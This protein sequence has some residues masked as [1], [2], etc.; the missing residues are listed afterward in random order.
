MFFGLFV[1]RFPDL[2]VLLHKDS[3]LPFWPSIEIKKWNR[4]HMSLL[5]FLKDIMMMILKHFLAF[6]GSSL[7]LMN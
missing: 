5:G 4:I 2:I 1:L 7:A 3:P 6:D